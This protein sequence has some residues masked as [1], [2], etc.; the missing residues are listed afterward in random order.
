M[1]LLARRNHEG[2][3]VQYF[4]TIPKKMVEAK[5]WKA[6]EKINITFGPHGEFVLTG[7]EK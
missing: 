4:L 1:K 7:G 6:G 2:K 3:I 5:G